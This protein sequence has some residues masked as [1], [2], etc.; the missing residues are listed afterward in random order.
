[1]PNDK[2]SIVI[3]I[4][5]GI[6]IDHFKPSDVKVING[7]KQTKTLLKDQLKFLNQFI[8]MKMILI[9]Q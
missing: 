6:Y 1:M 5:N 8:I 2:K 9:Q 7:T 3:D 4:N